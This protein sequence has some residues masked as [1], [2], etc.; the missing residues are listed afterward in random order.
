MSKGK[1]YNKECTY[2]QEDNSCM[3]NQ[4]P[5]QCENAIVKADGRTRSR[6]YYIKVLKSPS[7]ACGK[8]KDEKRAFCYRCWE[9][10][11]GYLKLCLKRRIGDGFEEGYEDCRQFLEKNVW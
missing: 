9:L 8:Y 5:Q 4:H 1:C 11:P 2:H 3:K 10:L 6:T 7:C